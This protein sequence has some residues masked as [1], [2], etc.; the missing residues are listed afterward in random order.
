MKSMYKAANIMSNRTNDPYKSA[1]W[2][3]MCHDLEHKI[4]K[5]DHDGE[6]N[7]EEEKGGE[8]PPW[9]SPPLQRQRWGDGKSTL[10]YVNC[11]Y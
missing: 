5:M 4:K 8:R 2:S 11:E 6:F 1:I 10:P 9:Y 7:S 3:T